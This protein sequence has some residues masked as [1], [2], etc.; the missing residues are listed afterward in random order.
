MLVF[1][2]RSHPVSPCPPIPC[3]P[4]NGRIKLLMQLKGTESDGCNRSTWFTT[5]AMTL[6]VSLKVSQPNASDQ[7]S[8]REAKLAYIFNCWFL[9]INMNSLFFVQKYVVSKINQFF[10]FFNERKINQFWP[11]LKQSF[12]L[13]LMM[14]KGRW[15]RR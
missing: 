15:W 7:G 12:D 13:I 5:I 6:N 4:V 1:G 10:F 14:T 3:R 11:I 2:P 9:C 8:S